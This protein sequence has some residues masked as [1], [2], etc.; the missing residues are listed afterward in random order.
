MA[1]AKITT[2]DPIV[3]MIWGIAVQKILIWIQ[4]MQRGIV[5]LANV[6]SKTH[7]GSR[8]FVLDPF[9]IMILVIVSNQIIINKKIGDFLIISSKY[10]CNC[11]ISLK[12]R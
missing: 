3:I 12:K 6:K 1:F 8:M 7:G 9:T 10:V 11:F 5:A 4:V 2:M